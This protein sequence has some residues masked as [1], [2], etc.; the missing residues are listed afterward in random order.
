MGMADIRA[1][2]YKCNGFLNSSSLEAVSTIFPRNMTATR[3][4]I[5]STTDSLWA[6]N[7]YVRLNSSCKSL[8]KFNTWDWM[9][10]SNA[11][12]GSS[13]TM[14]FGRS[15]RAQAMAIAGSNILMTGTNAEVESAI[16]SET[17]VIDLE[18]KMVLPGFIDAHSHPSHSM[19]FFGNIHLYKLDN[20]ENYEREITRFTQ[21][22]PAAAVYRGSGWSD[23]LFPGIGPSKEILDEIVPDRPISLV[24]Y[25]G[26]SLWVNS[27]T[28]E[29]VGI[30]KDTPDPN[31]GLI[32]RDPETGEPGGTLRETAMRLVANVFPDYSTD[33]MVN[34]LLSYQEMAVQAGV[35]MTHDAM[36]DGQCIAAFK[37]VEAN[38][39]LRMRFR[40]AITVHPDLPI[41]EQLKSLLEQRAKNKHPHF[42]TIT[43]K[44]FVDGVVEGGTAYL[45]APYHH[46]PDFCG[47][48]IWRP[49]LLR[50]LFST[51]DREKIQIH[52][53]VIGDDAVR[54]TLDVLEYAQASNG[55]RDS[56]HLLTHLQLVAPKD[57]TRFKQ[58]NVLGMPNP[59]WFKVDD[60]YYR[61][62][63]PYLGSARADRQY[64]MRSLLDAGVIMA[65][66][67][68]F[69]VTIPFDPLI[70]I[71]L[72]IT[73]TAIDEPSS[74]VLWPT[75]RATLEEM[76]AS[77]TWNGAY[78][79]FMEQQI[80][81][82]QAGKQAD[83]IV[84]DQNLFKIFSAEIADTKVL[85]TYIDGQEVFRS[86]ELA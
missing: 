36:L 64:P 53:H 7:K 8:S 24:S 73:R 30:T 26:H 84:L 28:P 35:T 3:S 78:A 19:D 6:M 74:D 42:R 83:F 70:G 67:S 60:Y 75:E 51:L 20:V 69:P 43:A 38:G 39:L 57:V 5:C 40:G 62:A 11:E 46:K 21:S 34:A 13:H 15:T 82:L 31:G 54:I 59:Y 85:L 55:K 33:E 81:S 10:T 58:L 12:T 72:G 37:R 66:A 80:G 49:E 27:V 16:G 9:D 41:V 56:R 48:P 61:L 2:V 45:L 1:W 22:Y 63:L 18:G 23:S 86:A 14:N 77:F 32:E 25:D 29:R 79:N 65:S 50:D 4:E 68:E 71:Q 76:I 52:A 44:V 47:V 17:D